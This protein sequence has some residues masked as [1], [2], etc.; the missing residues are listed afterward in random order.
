MIHGVLK[1]NI[2][3]FWQQRVIDPAHQLPFGKFDSKG[4]PVA[5]EPLGAILMVR[6]LWAF[7][8]TYHLLGTDSYLQTAELMNRRI[9]KYFWD[10][11]Q[12]GLFYAVDRD[13]S[14][15]NPAKFVDCQ[16]YAIY[17]FCAFY[18]A[19]G[20]K[21]ALGYAMA[22]FEYIEA[23]VPADR[24]GG[25]PDL[26]Y[27]IYKSDRSLS[28]ENITGKVLTRSLN[29]HLHL[30][31]AYTSLYG[32]S[33]DGRV[34]NRLNL[35]LNIIVD[36]FYGD[37]MFY[38]HLS[39][40]WHA[41][42]N[43]TLYGL[44]LETAWLLVQAADLL[45]SD[46]GYSQKA[47]AIL[48]ACA[49]KTL[50]VAVDEDG[51]VFYAGNGCQPNDLSK[52]WWVQ[53]EAVVAFLVAYE[54]SLKPHYFDAFLMSWDFILQHLVDRTIGEWRLGVTKDH[55]VLTEDHRVGFWKCP[56]H[57]TR[58]CLETLKRGELIRE[59][60]KSCGQSDLFGGC[61]EPSLEDDEFELGKQ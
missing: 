10:K 15:L 22:L 47:Y 7:S 2:L 58:A 50:A 25:Y 39:S 17:A 6:I 44:N 41:V 53:A 3:S 9:L 18:N 4:E 38:S 36:H 56:Y 31:E 51:A 33:K 34:R 32:A 42:D 61:L 35:L 43:A 26:L 54:K 21:A 5:D 19:V 28:S 24:E 27:P 12:G 16:A 23:H 49:S 11:L 52:Q 46:Q 40:D 8:A 57:N 59:G 1:E 13:A 45:D 30:L 29:T 55:A 48:T 20:D 37:G 60:L 14:V